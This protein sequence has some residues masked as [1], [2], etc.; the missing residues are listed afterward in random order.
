M[1]SDNR[2]TIFVNERRIKN[3]E[4][5]AR[6]GVHDLFLLQKETPYPN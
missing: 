2:K 6:L 4:E 1:A 5:K 3:R